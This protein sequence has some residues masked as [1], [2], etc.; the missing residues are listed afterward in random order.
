M[1]WRTGIQNI[2]GHTQYFV[3][4]L[5][6]FWVGFGITSY[7]EFPPICS[8]CFH[9]TIITHHFLSLAFSWPSTQKLRK[10][11]VSPPLP[12]SILVCL[13]ITTHCMYAYYTVH[14]SDKWTLVH[15]NWYTMNVLVFKSTRL[16]ALYYYLFL[17]QHLNC[18]ILFWV[19]NAWNYWCRS[20]L[21]PA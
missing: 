12:I 5:S 13:L 19:R 3:S 15:K 7:F 8:F 9:H 4:V 1:D 16:L 11:L 17:L 14:A 20:N 10:G 18:L 6:V 21:P 2:S